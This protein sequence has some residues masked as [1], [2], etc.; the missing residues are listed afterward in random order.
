MNAFRK[1]VIGELLASAMF[2]AAAQQNPP[3]GSPAPPQNQPASP[4]K[5]AMPVA[6]KPASSP[7]SSDDSGRWE[8]MK[9]RDAEVDRRLKEEAKKRAE[10]Q[11]K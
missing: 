11:K 10:Q 6:A 4:A 8:R 3:P 2:L 7:A 9:Q 1:F 5:P